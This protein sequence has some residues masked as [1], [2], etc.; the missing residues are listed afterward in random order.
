MMVMKVMTLLEP[1]IPPSLL[2]LVNTAVVETVVMVAAVV[3]LVAAVVELVAAVVNLVA[4]VVES[5]AVE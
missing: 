2:L 1:T 5:V 3:K 4:A